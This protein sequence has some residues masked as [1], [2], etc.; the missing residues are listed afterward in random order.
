MFGKI[1]QWWRN[2]TGSGDAP[3]RRL[4]VVSAPSGAGK[5]S[6]V[7]ALL[8]RNP[9]IKMSTSYTTR[10][11]RPGEVDG[12]DY[13]FVNA[14][15]FER[16]EGDGELL[17]SAI[18]FE[19]R[20]GTSRAHVN[21]LLAQGF[22]VILEIDWQGAQQVREA[23]PSCESVFI[24]PPSRDALAERLRGR[25]TDSDAVIAK[26]LSESVAEMSHWNEFDYVVVNADFDRAVDDLAAIV[27]GNGA[28]LRSDRPELRDL[29]AQLLA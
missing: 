26:R 22:D 16:L 5:T 28:P 19:N 29:T 13:F 6:L 15:E 9:K 4:L 21:E 25:S 24:L 11:K 12:K 8:E 2:L 18:V 7:R 27:T 14:H 10:P 17:E 3:P 1:A 20:Y 23:S